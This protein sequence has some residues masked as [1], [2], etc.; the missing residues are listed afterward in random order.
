MNGRLIRSE[1]GQTIVMTLL[2]L[3]VLIA[4]A[5]L[6]IDVGSWYVKREKAQ[7]AA[8]MGAL[9]AAAELPVFG[10]ARSAGEE[11]V[12]R[13]LADA[14]P[15]VNPGYAGDSA[16]VE[17]RARTRGETFFLGLFG[18][19]SVGISARAVAQKYAA[20]VPLAIFV[21]DDDCKGYGFGGNGDDW[22]VAGGVHSNGSFKVNGNDILIGGARAGGPNDCEPVVNGDN[23]RF[24]DD[25]EPGR[26]GTREDWP[27]YFEESEF[28]CDFRA[29]KF[30]FARE[31]ET[32]PSGVYCASESFKANA[33]NQTGRITV[34]APE[35]VVNGN[36]QRFE[37]YAKGVLFFA[38][39]DKEMVLDAHAFQWSGIIFHPRGRVK[40]NG[41]SA[42][43]LNGLI[44][45]FHVEVNGN[46]F[47]MNGTGPESLDDIALIE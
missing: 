14:S 11:Y 23:I 1:R 16:K 3:S 33:N 28:A 21:Y 37:P 34:L 29:Q 17:V 12:G 43:V 27:L 46:G 5:G 35:I 31:G 38:T 19:D 2:F 39:G 6:V 32:I 36:Y 10:A 41:D 44:E 18:F 42:S 26:H 25:D 15:E 8:D 9:A 13:N 24:G 4:M 47:T 7:A 20:A 45:G 22:T 40:I 30:E